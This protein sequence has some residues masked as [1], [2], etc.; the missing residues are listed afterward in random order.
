[1]TLLTYSG[2]ILIIFHQCFLFIN[3]YFPQTC[4]AHHIRPSA[5]RSTSNTIHSTRHEAYE[6]SA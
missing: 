2:V 5:Q 6:V 1:M 3:I 4:P